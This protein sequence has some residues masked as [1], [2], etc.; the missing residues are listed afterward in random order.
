MYLLHLQIPEDQT[1]AEPGWLGGENH[2][3]SGWFPA[4]YVEKIEESSQ[5]IGTSARYD[6][7]SL[8]LIPLLSREKVTII[9]VYTLCDLNYYLGLY[10]GLCDHY[11]SLCGH[12]QAT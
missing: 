8:N 3:K 1:G 9:C 5:A 6:L 7:S 10:L 12:F 2:G 11:L 4:S